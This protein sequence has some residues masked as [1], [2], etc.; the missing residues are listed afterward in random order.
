[1]VAALARRH[2]TGL[3]DATT[4]GYT[5]DGLSILGLGLDQLPFALDSRA[6]TGSTPL[7][8]AFDND[9]RLGYF[10]GPPMQ[11]KIQTVDS[12]LVAGKRSMIT[13]FRPLAD[14]AAITG[15][16]ATK[17]TPGGDQR[18]RSEVP[19]NRT[20][21]VPQITSGMFH[22]FEVTIPPQRWSN[23]HGVYPEQVQPDGDQ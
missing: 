20:G 15:R 11:A 14:A 1:M 4:P 21:L 10:A 19:V 2:F 12:Q 23:T 16:T 13:G 5:L 7:I 3:I 22:R 9:M 8:A 6:W 18:W 17:E